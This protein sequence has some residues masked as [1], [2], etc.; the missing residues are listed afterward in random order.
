[1]VLQLRHVLYI[2]CVINLCMIVMPARFLFTFINFMRGGFHFQCSV[3][4]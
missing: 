4:I 1:M 2:I 3:K